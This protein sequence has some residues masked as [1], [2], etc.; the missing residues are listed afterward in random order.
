[1]NKT[2]IN[3]IAINEEAWYTRDDTQEKLKALPLKLQWRI[4]KNMKPLEIIAKEF[5]DFRTELEQKRNLEWFL[6]GNGKCKKITQ[7]NGEEVLQ[8]LDDCLD[9]FRKYEEDLNRQINEVIQEE[10]TIEYTPIDLE[11]IIELVD[12]MEDMAFTM[13]DLDM[14]SIFEKE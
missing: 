2:I 4:R 6:E 8:I 13:D 11:E 14:L 5:K 12:S 10:A 3:L 1:M 9:D 7:E